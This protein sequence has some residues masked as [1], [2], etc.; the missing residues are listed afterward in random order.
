[1]PGLFD[2]FGKRAGVLSTSE[3]ARVYSPPSAAFEHMVRWEPCSFLPPPHY[4]VMQNWQDPRP[5]H[6]GG[7]PTVGDYPV[8]LAQAEMPD[9]SFEYVCMLARDFLTAMTVMSP[10]GTGKTHL[11]KIIL[12]EMLRIGAGISVTDFKADLVTDLLNG[13]IP[14]EQERTTWVVDLADTAW[15]PAINPLAQPRADRARIADSIETLFSRFDETFSKGVGMKEFLRNAALALVE[16]GDRP[17]LLKLHRFML[18]EPYRLQ[19][20]EEK[21]HDV[22]VREFWL[23]DFPNRGDTQKNSVDA[24]VRRLGMFLMNPVIRHV[25]CRPST[26]LDFREAMDRGYNVLASV[27]VESIGNQI[28]GFAAMMV[29]ELLNTAAFSR[30]ADGVPV[31]ERRFFLN[32]VDEFQQAVASGD[33]V[34]VATQISKLRAMGVGSVYLYQSS[35]QIPA[36]LRAQIES[37][38]ANTI[39]LGALGGDIPTLVQRWGT[40]LAAEDFAGMRRREDLY[41]QIQVNEQKTPPFRGRALPLWPALKPPDL[42]IAPKDDWRS[43]RAPATDSWHTWMDARIDAIIAYERESTHHRDEARALRSQANLLRRGRQDEAR[44]QR[45]SWER[46]QAAWPNDAQEL[47]ARAEAA[48]NRAIELERAPLRILRDAPGNIFELYR[49]R[50]AQH[51]L[52][53]LDYI[54]AHPAVIP[55]SRQRISTMSRLRLAAPAVEVAAY[56]ERTVHALAVATSNA[57]EAHGGKAKGKSAARHT[58]PVGQVLNPDAPIER[59]RRL[60]A[61]SSLL[62]ED[63]RSDAEAIADAT[64]VFSLGGEYDFLPDF[65]ES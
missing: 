22:L 27:P 6:P 43:V 60:P 3:C 64:P 23:R 21:V 25:V 41:M 18:S 9:G 4:A 33:P 65:G 44:E 8:R 59:L 42:G 29:Q 11:A 31:E 47:L 35:A 54:D 51:R 58:V 52:T 12:S 48:T 61:L 37:N 17:D 53:Q 38:V 28:G 1:M 62:A 10:M 26:T 20:V 16:A 30:S 2:L 24:L 14:R 5:L 45:D 7:L 63:Q 34:A 49:A 32:L 57:E 15:P 46:S 50:A 36:D 55:D 56:V 19:L 40:Y 13:M 39:C